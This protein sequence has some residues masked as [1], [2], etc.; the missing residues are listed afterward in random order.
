MVKPQD[1]QGPVRWLLYFLPILCIYLKLESG[2]RFYDQD[3]AQA[4]HGG[5]HSH[6]S[7]CRAKVGCNSLGRGPGRAHNRR[8]IR[9]VGAD[10]YSGINA[11]YPVVLLS[12][13]LK[14]GEPNGVRE[15]QR[16]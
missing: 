5:D 9:A 13:L 6:D 15:I 16:E 3:N 4:G 12:C 11:I 14:V 7:N 1:Q 2:W 8:E 10:D